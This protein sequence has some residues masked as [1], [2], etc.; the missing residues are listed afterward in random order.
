MLAVVDTSGRSGVAAG[1]YS[2]I[3]TASK[4]PAGKASNTS[5]RGLLHG[6]LPSTMSPTRSVSVP[7]A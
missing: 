5:Q 7:V 2:A 3:P 6:A 4:A 1:Q